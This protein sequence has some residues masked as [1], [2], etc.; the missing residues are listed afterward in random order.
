MISAF[1]WQNS[2]SLCPASFCIPRPSLLVT[3]TS[4]KRLSYSTYGEG[5]GDPLQ[6]SRLENPMDGGAW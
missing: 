4:Q 1:S 3:P 6:Y 5:N 2:I